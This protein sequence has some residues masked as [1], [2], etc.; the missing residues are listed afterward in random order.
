[1]KLSEEGLR[2]FFGPLEAQIMEIVWSRG[3]V[4]IKEVQSLLGEELSFNTVMTVLN[5]LSEKGHLKKNTI[6][7]GR[8]RISTFHPV[9]SK[10]E[11]IQE[12]TRIVTT[13]L[14]HE[15]G[16]IVLNHLFDAVQQA[17]PSL[18]ELLEARIDEWKRDK[19]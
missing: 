14:V 7:K 16:E 8:N 13:E 10:E 1:M 11:F 19:P 18:R 2:R 9:Q 15:Y 4:M 3:E 12:Q 17:D 6:G 5:R